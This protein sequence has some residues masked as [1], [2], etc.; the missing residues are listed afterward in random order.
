MEEGGDEWPELTTQALRPEYYGPS[1]PSEATDAD[2]E[3]VTVAHF[4]DRFG[5]RLYF[6]WNSITEREE[7][8]T[9]DGCIP[10]TLYERLARDLPHLWAM[11]KLNGSQAVSQAIDLAFTEKRHEAE[12]KINELLQAAL[13]G[14]QSNG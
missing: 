1:S 5:P 10:W 4:L 12:R 6:D 7:L 9:E 2:L 13:P 8:H 11:D 14:V 3:R